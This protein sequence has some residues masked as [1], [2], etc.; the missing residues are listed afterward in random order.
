[1]GMSTKR[2]TAQ[3]GYAALATVAI[4]ALALSTFILTTFNGNA[5]RN[6]QDRKTITALGVARDALISYAA[7]DPTHDPGLLPC[8]DTDNDGSADSPCGVQY[9]TVIGRLPW[10][11]LGLTDLR[12]G[13]DECLWYVVSGNFKNSGTAAPAWV[14]STSLGTLVVN[15]DLG[16]AITTPNS[17]VAIVFAPGSPLAGQDRTAAGASVCG[18]NTNPAAYLDTAGGVNNATGNGASTY[19]AGNPSAT[20]NDQLLYLATD[21]LFAA[22]NRRVLAEL[23]GAT[24]GTLTGLMAYYDAHS[25]SY[26]WAADG[27]GSQVISQTS[28]R[29]AYSDSSVTST[30]NAGTRARL[31]GNGWWPL[32][33]YSVQAAPPRVQL[34]LGAVSLPVCPAAGTTGCP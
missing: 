6:E 18:G 19:V 24:T 7:A 14:N 21:Q 1:M 10:R 16:A 15:N 20:F 27:T 29:F 11:T 12:D 28:G 25:S 5:L 8:P 30:V 22:V 17:V 3:R 33:S 23:R 34:A 32:I 2:R 26:P 13:T 9:A 4:I 31:T